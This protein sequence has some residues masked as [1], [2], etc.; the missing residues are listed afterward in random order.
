MELVLA[1][2]QSFHSSNDSLS[3]SAW[4]RDDADA[5]SDALGLFR[6]EEMGPVIPAL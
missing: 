5:F 1:R 6:K 2:K 3:K 4:P